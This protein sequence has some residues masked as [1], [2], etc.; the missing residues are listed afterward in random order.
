MAATD[1]DSRNVINSALANVWNDG[2]V[3]LEVHNT[4]ITVSSNSGSTTV[5]W[6]ESF[7]DGEVYVFVTGDESGDFSSSSSGSSQATINADNTA[8]ASGTVNANVLAVGVDNSA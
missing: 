7:A 6:N 5:S 1:G 4:D 8:T 3:R 2:D